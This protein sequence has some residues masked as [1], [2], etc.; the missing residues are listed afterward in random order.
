MTRCKI[1]PKTRRA[2]GAPTMCKREAAKIHKRDNQELLKAKAHY[3][4]EFG[5]D[6]ALTYLQCAIVQGKVIAVYVKFSKG[7]DLIGM[8]VTHAG[9]AAIF[10][11]CR[12]THKFINPRKLDTKSCWIDNDVI[13]K[14]LGI[15][16]NAKISIRVI[17][18][19]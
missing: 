10:D 18:K 1:D 13:R 2:K 4:N 6:I 11:Y 12:K 17:R 16:D 15:S 14:A 5:A 7:Y 19:R 3:S 8:C 9:K